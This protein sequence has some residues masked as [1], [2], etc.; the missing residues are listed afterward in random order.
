MDVQNALTPNQGF[1]VAV[2]DGIVSYSGYD[3]KSGYYVFIL[4]PNKYKT[5]YCHMKQG[6]VLVKKGDKVVKGQRIGLMGETGSAQ[7][8]HLHFGVKNT[9]PVW[10]DPLPVLEGKLKLNGEWCEGEYTVLKANEALDKI[11]EIIGE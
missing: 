3:S 5:F 10:V 9:A 1:G 7:G 2:E 6:S 11:L 8:V 4:H